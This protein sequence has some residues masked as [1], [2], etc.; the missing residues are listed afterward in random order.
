LTQQHRVEQLQLSSV[1]ERFPH[2]A[3]V[4][5][6]ED[7]TIHAVN[8]AYHELL[9]G[10]DIDKVALNEVFGGKD[11]E[12]FIKVLK[13][14]VRNTESINTAPIAASVAGK[15]SDSRRFVHTIVPISDASGSKVSRLFVYSEGVE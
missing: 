12:E 11:M 15:D 10:R 5:N 6:A 3:M 8:P 1:L 7:L 4:L 2:Y 13:R 14:A 9:E